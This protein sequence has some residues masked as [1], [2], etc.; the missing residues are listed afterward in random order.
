MADEM[1]DE[2]TTLG[3]RT[4]HAAR[5]CCWWWAY[6]VGAIFCERPARVPLSGKHVTVEFRDGWTV[7][8]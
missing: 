8:T 1:A 2:N 4:R 5:S 6:D 7:R 3:M